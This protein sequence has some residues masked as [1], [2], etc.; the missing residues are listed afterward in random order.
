[1][2]IKLLFSDNLISRNRARWAETEIKKIKKVA[3][4]HWPYDEKGNS[5]D[6]TETTSTG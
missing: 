6:K 5:K 2:R 4:T 1:M 3:D